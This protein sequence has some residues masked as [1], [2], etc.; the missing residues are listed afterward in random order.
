[1][2]GAEWN[3][4][5]SVTVSRVVRATPAQ[6]RDALAARPDFD[7]PLPPFL[8]LGFPVPVATAGSG[9]TPG[10]ERTIVFEHVHGGHRERG[11]LVMRIANSDSTF[12]RFTPVRDDSYVTHWLAWESA[13]VRWQATSA[14]ETRVEWTLRYKR[15]LD[16]AWYFAPLERYGVGVAA[17]YLVEALATPSARTSRMPVGSETPL[18]H[19][20]GP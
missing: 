18:E 8:R 2:P 13:E 1:M 3:R 15:R 11:T 20:H 9:F 10:D 19:A 17:G 16:P 7:T 5:D 4:H 14:T 12:V 6:V